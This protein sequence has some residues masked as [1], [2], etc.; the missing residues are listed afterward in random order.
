MTAR[1]TTRTQNSSPALRVAAAGPC[2]E[3]EVVAGPSTSS[4]SRPGATATSRSR[5]EERKR[6]RKR[7]SRVH[8]RPRGRTGQPRAGSTFPRGRSRTLRGTRTARATT[9]RRGRGPGRARPPTKTTR[10]LLLDL[11][12]TT[13]SSER[14]DEREATVKGGIITITPIAM[15]IVMLMQVTPRSITRGRTSEVVEELLRSEIMIKMMM[16]SMHLKMTLIGTR[17]R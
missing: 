14:A 1:A 3:H 2:D 16:K 8:P 4:R 9:R 7:Q 15:A 6:K 11:I 13:N 17:K 12:K 10:I 5:S